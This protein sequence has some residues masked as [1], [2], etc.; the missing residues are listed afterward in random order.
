MNAEP[1]PDPAARRERLDALRELARVATALIDGDE[2][3]RIIVDRAYHHLA[4]PS[5]EHPFLVGDHFD[6]DGERFLRMKKFLLRIETLTPFACDTA[7]WVRV[8]GREDHVTVACQNGE[9]KRYY[10]FGEGARPAERNRS[11]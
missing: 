9:M 5:E 2:A 7:L 4:N 10:R 11:R 3:R 1:L 6:V 8:K